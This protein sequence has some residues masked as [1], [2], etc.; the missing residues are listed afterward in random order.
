MA[1]PIGNDSDI[2]QRAR[3]TLSAVDVIAAE[4]TRVFQKLAQ[5]LNLKYKKVIS[6]HEHNERNSAKGLIE[7]LK[8]GLQLA[9]VSDAGTPQ[10]SDPGHHLIKLALDADITITPLPGPSALTATISICPFGGLDFYFGGFLPTQSKARQEAFK[11]A[12]CRLIFYEAPHRLFYH[13]LE[14]QKFFGE[15]QRVF[16]TREL[17]KP[18]EETF[19]GTI[20]EALDHWTK[21]PPKGEFVVIYEERKSDASLQ[22]QKTD[23][24]ELLTAKI[25]KELHDGLNP[26]EILK[27]AQKIS[28]LDRKEIYNLILSLKKRADEKD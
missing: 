26:K 8:A 5:R 11:S 2:S 3:E 20:D 27:E 19:L 21:K 7:Q 15:D 28:D 16:I 14:A 1:L 12:S 9:L 17:T 6:H 13:L 25:Q 18:Y 4:D 24:A 22:A 23:Q 10:I